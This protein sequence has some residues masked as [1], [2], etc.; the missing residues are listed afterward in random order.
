[1]KSVRFLLAIGAGTAR[2]A[3][4]LVK[5][6]PEGRKGYNITVLLL[7]LR[8]IRRIIRRTRVSD[9]RAT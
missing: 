5:E 3:N 2:P 7:N 6:T 8:R 1:M 9:K 4:K